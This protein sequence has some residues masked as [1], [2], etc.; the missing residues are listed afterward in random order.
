MCL[1]RT[2]AGLS[3]RLSFKHFLRHPPQAFPNTSS[4][5]IINYCKKEW[6]YFCTSNPNEKINYATDILDKLTFILYRVT[7]VTSMINLF[8]YLFG[9][10]LKPKSIPNPDPNPKSQS[11]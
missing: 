5:N 10:E 3:P 8:A 6:I 11:K 1:I 4:T 7:M 9:F 2:V